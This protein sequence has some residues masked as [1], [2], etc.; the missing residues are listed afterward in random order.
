MRGIVF[1]AAIVATAGA[2]SGAEAF[3]LAD[4]QVSAH[5]DNPSLRVFRRD[6][7]YEL[8]GATM[9]DLVSTA[10]S[11][12]PDEVSGGPSWLE[13]DRFDVIAKI[14]DSATAES[15]KPMLRSLLAERFGLTLHDDKALRPAW[16][17]TAGAH[18]KMTQSDADSEGGC[19][20]QRSAHT[21][22]LNAVFEC[23]QVSMSAFA[24]TLRTSKLPPVVG[25]VAGNEVV[26]Q[27]GLKGRWDFS[28]KWSGTGLMAKAGPDGITLF[29]AIEK[30]PG[31]Q[32]KMG[33]AM[34]PVVVVDRVN[35]TPTANAPD[36]TQKLPALRLQFDVVD[37]RPSQQDKPTAP[38][39]LPGGRLDVRGVALIALIQHAWGLDTYDNDLIADGPKWLTTDR[40]D[41]LAK[42]TPPEASSSSLKDDDSLREMLR[43]MLKD[44]FNLAVR[45][46]NREVT[47]FALT[48]VKP[49]LKQADASERSKCTES[50]APNATAGNIPQRMIVC[51]NVSMGEF[52]DRLHGMSPGYANRPVVDSTGLNGAFDFSVV[53]SR[54][55]LIRTA[56]R[57]GGESDLAD[58]N[59][60][61][62]LYEAVEKQLGLKMATT[63]RMMPVLVIDHVE[64]APA[65]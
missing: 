1:I 27:T 36:V 15:L 56:E 52:A 32:L 11:V 7:R 34:L 41:I 28:L 46:E 6:G 45:S 17:L 49:K 64:K 23:K 48:A 65:N 24:E 9:V 57:L 38:K 39:L 51:T 5:S 12:T 60:A 35:R 3:E 44:N 29:D 10:Y 37:I 13:S 33:Q 54:P 25:Y 2:L 31:L 8:L 58:P 61:M 50:A 63:K 40:Y 62:T 26:D 47:V 18:P 19:E 43:N 22:A 42:T 16:L 4:V 20:D 21:A 59:G 53:Y 14:P 30:Q 55:G